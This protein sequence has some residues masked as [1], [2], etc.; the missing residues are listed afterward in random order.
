MKQKLEKFHKLEKHKQHLR[1]RF[2][3][4]ISTQTEKAIDMESKQKDQFVVAYIRNFAETESVVSCAKALS[5]ILK[6]GIILLY[7]IEPSSSLTTS[8]AEERMKELVGTIQ[9]D[10]LVSYIVLSG[11]P[12]V[13]FSAL[14]EKIGAVCFVA[15][16]NKNERSLKK[17]RPLLQCFSESR[18]A[19]CIAH[20]PVNDTE[21]LKKIALSIDFERQSKEKVLWANYFGRFFQS[22]I[23]CFHY[24]YKDE[25]L[26][27][28]FGDN[29]AFVSKM[30][31]SF[32]VPFHF[33]EISRGKRWDLE[34][35]ALAKAVSSDAGLYI[36]IATEGKNV[37][38]Y[39]S[40]TSEEKLLMFNSNMPILFLNPRKDLYVL[41]D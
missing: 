19:Y 39:F 32:Q 13:I 33:I 28:R 10:Y 21:S 26:R 4:D 24:N 14:P 17:I 22:T 36:S 40:G 29:Q 27:K 16:L 35:D 23:E 12:K 11:S 7:I 20:S 9:S 3:Q 18:V 38:S 37:F 6:K 8:E 25:F 41:C 1:K 5:S 34:T 15:S 30:L 31:S 2:G